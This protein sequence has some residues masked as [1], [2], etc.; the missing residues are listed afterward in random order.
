MREIVENWSTSNI[1]PQAG[2]T[3][4]VTGAN[5]GIGYETAL[6]LGRAG[7][8][9]TVA[10]RDEQRG[11]DAVAR[12]EAATPGASFVFEQ[13]D[14]ADLASVRAMAKRW[15][16]GGKPLDLL[17]NNAGVM[18]LPKRELTVDGFERQMGTNHLGHFALTGL[19]LPALKKSASPRVVSLSSAMAYIGKMDLT[20]LQSERRYSGYMTYSATKLA[21]LLFMEELGRRE[22][23]LVSVAAHPG[24]TRTNLQ[25]HAGFFTALSMKLVG[26]DPPDGAL[27]TLYAAT[28]AIATG[29]FI[30][31]RKLFH[32]N[33]PPVEVKLPKRAM[34]QA[35]ARALWERS[36]ELTGVRYEPRATA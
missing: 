9:V 34:D 29:E 13:L 1:P 26:Q 36:E 2:K 19:L 27:P 21:N 24:G 8:S 10:C 17:V 6:A 20:N 4:I 32:M 16:D 12:L 18:A 22:P 15:I 5:S 30:G 35:A 7:A 31:P 25:Q 3:A 11:R 28:D 23:W 14:L 33:G